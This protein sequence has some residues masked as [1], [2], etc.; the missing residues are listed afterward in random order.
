MDSIVTSSS[1]SPCGI[2]HG[3]RRDLV[4]HVRSGHDLAEDRVQRVQPAALRSVR[5]TKNW[6]SLVWRVVRHRDRVRNVV[7]PFRRRLDLELVAGAAAAHPLE[8]RVVR[9]RLR[10]TGLDDEAGED[11]VEP[12]AVVEAAAGEGDEVRRRDRRLV[13]VELEREL[14]LRRPR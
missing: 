13:A 10:V 6:L 2:G 14:V 4:D 5:L 8:R 9:L 3:H 12:D 1:G 7:E 11:P